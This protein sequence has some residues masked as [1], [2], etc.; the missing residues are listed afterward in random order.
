MFD[1]R[2]MIVRALAGSAL[3]LC[4]A[5]PAAAIDVSL[6]G[7]S[8]SLGGNDSGGLDAGVGVSVGGVGAGVSTSVGGGG[9]SADVSLGA[10]G[11]AAGGGTGGTGG[12]GS[13]STG[14]SAGNGGG[15]F[16]GRDASD[17]VRSMSKAERTR[18][19]KSCRGILLDPNAYKWDLVQLCK[20]LAQAN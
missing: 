5:S 15:S 9:I 13:A 14:G 16:G 8:A 18:N 2:K 12:G 1:F 11:G 4:V 19:M 6:G 20:M 10:D 7:I 3:A 17:V